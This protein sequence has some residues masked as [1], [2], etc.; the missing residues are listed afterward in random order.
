MSGIDRYYVSKTK[1]ED[2]YR[3]SDIVEATKD[4][5]AKGMRIYKS[6]PNKLLIDLDVGKPSDVR[7]KLRLLNELLRGYLNAGLH[8]MMRK[9]GME[10][11]AYTP[12]VIEKQWRSKS[13]HWHIIVKMDRCMS[14][15]ERMVLQM[16]LGSDSERD[17]ISLICYWGGDP[18]PQ[19]LFRPSLRTEKARKEILRASKTSKA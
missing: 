6:C 14:L 4:A 17:M 1:G 7:K 15:P 5:E 13:G 12:A 16:Y 8:E 11:L 2:D 10:R 3:L 18:E 19:F 9:I